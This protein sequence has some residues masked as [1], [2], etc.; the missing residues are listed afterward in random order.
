MTQDE[1]KAVL[2][3][4]ALAMQADFDGPTQ[5][6]YARSLADIPA[7]LLME[8]VAEAEREADLRFFPRAPEWR[9]RCERVRRKRLALHPFEPCADCHGIG[10]VRTSAPGV[11]PHAYGPC[12]C[13]VRYEQQIEQMGLSAKPLAQLPAVTHDYE[14]GPVTVAPSMDDLPPAVT[15][16]IRSIAEARRIR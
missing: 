12:A 7:S 10:K 15:D 14:D 16:K 2:V 13:R 3:P 5:R 1:L 4:F 11:L 8:A 9:G 6:A